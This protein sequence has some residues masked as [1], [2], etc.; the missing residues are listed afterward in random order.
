KLASRAP[1]FSLDSFPI[2]VRR[3]VAPTGSES[4]RDADNAQ[5]REATMRVFL[6]LAMGVF[7][8][9][10]MKPLS[11]SAN[12]SAPITQIQFDAGHAYFTQTG[13]D[14]GGCSLNR[15]VLDPTDYRYPALLSAF[16][17]GKNVTLFPGACRFNGDTGLNLLTIP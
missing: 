3:S 1:S 4:L 5:K 16:M 13:A 6:L 17:E 12:V 15:Y 2:V 7:G 10:C 11:A 14:Y 8:A 9:L